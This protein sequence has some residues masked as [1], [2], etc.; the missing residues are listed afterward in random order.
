[1]CNP[2]QEGH[3]QFYN[4]YLSR[5]YNYCIQCGSPCHSEGAKYQETWLDPKIVYCSTLPSPPQD[6]G[7]TIN[8]KNLNYKVVNC[9]YI[10]APDISKRRE[11]YNTYE[12][13]D[14]IYR[15]EKYKTR[16]KVWETEKYDKSYRVLETKH[17]YV[18][19][20]ITGA[21][22][23]YTTYDGSSSEEEVTKYVEVEKTRKVPTNERTPLVNATKYRDEYPYRLQYVLRLHDDIYC[24]CFVH[25]RKNLGNNL[26]KFLETLSRR[27]GNQRRTTCLHCGHPCHASVCR[28][29]GSDIFSTNFICCCNKCYCIQCVSETIPSS[30]F[31]CNTN[32]NIISTIS[33][34]LPIYREGNR[35]LYEDYLRCI[36]K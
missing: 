26:V 21:S 24:G 8:Y 32:D 12:G 13:G 27:D 7:K 5:E 23:G 34:D 3:E 25:Q 6:M 4:R 30:C 22:Y 18:N 33:S 19:G 35:S 36:L 20:R 29:Y 14:I 9:F 1:M 28:S 10:L 16:E 31:L 2:C 15:D 17:H 11:S